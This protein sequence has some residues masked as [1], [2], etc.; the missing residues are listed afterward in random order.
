VV[1]IFKEK[2]WLVRELAEREGTAIHERL[3][4]TREKTSHQ[5]N[6]IFDPKHEPRQAPMPTVNR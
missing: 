5:L 2:L 6:R 4:D 1:E 3:D